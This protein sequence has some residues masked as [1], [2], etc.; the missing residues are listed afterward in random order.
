MKLITRQIQ[1]DEW[2]AKQIENFGPNGTY[3]GFSWVHPRAREIGARKAREV[4]ALGQHPDP[5]LV[6][7]IAGN[8]FEPVACDEC[9]K[10]A[11]Q[12]VELGLYAEKADRPNWLCGDCLIKAL[13]LHE[14][15]C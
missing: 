11:P 13:N 3:F 8:Q 15:E 9:G 14:E 7:R 10:S 5:T 1:A 6:E 4:A 2:A 12:V